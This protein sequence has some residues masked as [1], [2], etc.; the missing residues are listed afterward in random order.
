MSNGGSSFVVREDDERVA[1]DGLD[2]HQA[3]VAEDLA[4]VSEEFRTRREHEQTDSQPVLVGLGRRHLGERRFAHE[5]AAE[6]RVEERRHVAHRRD[7]G[8]RRPGHGRDRVVARGGVALERHVRRPAADQSVH[9]RRT[10]D[11]ELR[12]VESERFDDPVAQDRAQVGRFDLLDHLAEQ[13]VVGVRVGE[14]DVRFAGGVS[15]MKPRISSGVKT[16]AR[17]VST[18]DMKSASSR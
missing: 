13:D 8:A 11:G 15:A 16:R 17:S 6:Q 12:R 1:R 10:R 14:L 18:S 7:D 3:Q 2:R 9:G 4:F 5:L